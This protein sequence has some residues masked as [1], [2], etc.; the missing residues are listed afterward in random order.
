MK[1]DFFSVNASKSRWQKEIQ[2]WAWLPLKQHPKEALILLA[3]ALPVLYIA[4][5]PD[6]EGHSSAL[7]ILLPLLIIWAGFHLG[8][9]ATAGLVLTSAIM[10]YLSPSHHPDMMYTLLGFALLGQVIAGLIYYKN[11]AEAELKAHLNKLVLSNQALD[12]ISQAVLITS[13]DYKIIYANKAFE[14]TNGIKQNEVIGKK[15]TFMQGPLSSPIIIEKIRT[16]LKNGQPFHGEIINYRKDGSHYW[17][18][19]SIIPIFNAQ[20]EITHFVS[21]QHDESERKITEKTIEKSAKKTAQLLEEIQKLTSNVPGMIYQFKLEKT[22][23]S[24][25]PY[26]SEGIRDLFL[27]SPEEILEDAQVLFNLI[28]PEDINELNSSILESAKTG[29]PWQLEYRTIFPDQ[30]LHWMLGNAQPEALDDGSI[31]WHGFI[32]DIYEI[33]QKESQLK[34]QDSKLNSILKSAADGIILIDSK[35]TMFLFNGAAEHIFGYTAAEV[36]HKNIRLLMQESEHSQHDQYLDNYLNTGDAKI[37]GIGREVMGKNKNGQLIPLDLSIS[38]WKLGNERMFTGIVRDIS[39]RKKVQAQLIQSQ[40]MDALSQLSGGLAHDFNNLLGII[41][42]N[43]D[44]IEP[45]LQGNAKA[46]ERQQSAIN[47]AMRGSDITRRLL[48]LSRKSPLPLNEIKPKSVGGLIEEVLGLLKRTLGADININ[49]FIEPNLPLITLDATTF[50][51]ALINLAINARDA[52]PDTGGDIVIYLHHWRPEIFNHCKDINLD[53]QAYLLLE[54]NDNGKGMSADV[55][56]RVFEPFF[57]TKTENGTGLGLAMVYGFV[58][59]LHGHIRVY[60]EQGIGTMFH[61]FLP[62]DAV[63][64]INI[65]EPASRHLPIQG[66]KETILLVDDEVDLRE[67]TAEHLTTFGYSVIQAKNGMDALD[68]LEHAG[69]VDL[70]LSDIVMP[71]G[72]DGVTLAQDI[73]ESCPHIAVLLTSGYPHKNS[74][75]D[76]SETLFGEILHKPYRRE[77]LMLAVRKRMD[78]KITA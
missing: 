54:F 57:S 58:K 53:N 72:M 8:S 52:M 9:V 64:N 50:E 16:A 61:I 40:K 1:D 38:E 13:V 29:E 67:V 17:N 39:E 37:I 6:L 25:F 10:I 69:K 28:H 43:L 2:L 48:Q 78:E 32:S 76:R 55:C 56:E 70:L 74:S 20:Q 49:T 63:Q 27:V 21:T 47:A 4:S 5:A 42:A 36:M 65:I 23:K 33:K 31:L 12:S 41:I 19:I 35:G 68:K 3:I 71:G 18:E 66:G 15:C 75:S 73:V 60:S 44:F 14:D 22:G 34:E 62:I 51:N 7:S 11:K 46:M 26:C 45:A 59:Q 24:Y 30:S 77:A